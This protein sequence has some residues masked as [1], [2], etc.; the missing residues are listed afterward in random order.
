MTTQQLIWATCT[1]AVAFIAAVYFTRATARRALGAFVAAAVAGA[2][3]LVM[4]FLGVTVGWWHV[5]LPSTAGRWAL[6]YAATAIS[7]APIYPVTWRVAR[8]F[9]SHGLGV[10]LIA[11][12]VIGPPRDYMIASVYPEW[13]VF[14]PGLTP[15]IAVS[16]T[17]V[18]VVALGHAIMRLVAGPA[19]GDRLA[20]RPWQAA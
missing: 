9:R 1:Y 15:I 7:W 3:F 16:V 19:Q 20:Q 17:Y 18:G 10:C 6:F 8:R 5:P 11:A 2:F 13:I 14:T 12:A 4:C